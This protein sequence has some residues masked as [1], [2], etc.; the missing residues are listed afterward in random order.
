MRLL[1]HVPPTE[2]DTRYSCK[3]TERASGSFWV[4]DK[5]EWQ[6]SFRAPDTGLIKL[7]GRGYCS[8]RR[9]AARAAEKCARQHRRY[10]S[11]ERRI[12]TTDPQQ[13]HPRV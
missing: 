12:R 7:I 2:T 8:T 5:W 10:Q 11:S 13:W 3:V 4:G 9:V 6:T 1:K